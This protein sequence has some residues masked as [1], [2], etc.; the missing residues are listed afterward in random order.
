MG[1]LAKFS[2]KQLIYFWINHFKCLTLHQLGQLLTICPLPSTLNVLAPLLHY[3]FFFF[4]G[5]QSI[6]QTHFHTYLSVRSY[7]KPWSRSFMFT[8]CGHMRTQRLP[9]KLDWD[10]VEKTH[11]K[12]TQEL[13][14]VWSADPSS[15]N[16]LCS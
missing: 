14:M 15:P 6:Q 5:I 1:W 12:T 11:F 16:I 2:G 4:V 8:L 7:C 10:V 13:C 9:N 3:L